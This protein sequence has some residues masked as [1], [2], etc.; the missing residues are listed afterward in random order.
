MV[1]AD[2]VMFHV[3]TQWL[4]IGLIILLLGHSLAR[5]AIIT[6]AWVPVFKGV[7]YTT[8]EADTNEVRLQKVF[9]F[10]LDLQEPTIE[11]FS[12]PANGTNGAL[13]TYGQTTTT[14]VNTYG[15]S[16][17]IN[18][19]FFSPVSTIP[20]D[21]RDL[22]GLAISG[23]D[24][25][26][27]FESGRPALL[28]TRSN[29][30]SIITSALSNY[31][32]YWTAVSGSD[33]I[34][35]NGVAQLASCTTSFCLE[36][37]RSALGYSANL[38]YLYLM[39]IDGRQPGWS[40]GATLYETGQW[41]LRLGA[42]NGLNLDGGG[43]TAL[44]RLESGSAILINRPSGGVQRVD[45]NHL[46]LFALPL[47]PM[48]VAQPQPTNGGLGQ[49]A[50]FT[51]TAGGTTPLRYQW[52]FNGTNISS[53]TSSSFAR[54]NLQLSQFG[55]YSVVITNFSG[56]I[57][58]STASLICANPPASPQISTHLSLS[59]ASVQLAVTADLGR[60]YSVQASS[61]LFQWVT[62]SK[63]F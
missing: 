62:L 35:I 55:Y 19:N 56:S 44:A 20:N 39:V 13:E 12:T 53:A 23:G 17:G 2:S 25:V 49:S 9:A 42:W 28:I 57:T 7:D 63:P 16:L 45:G 15:A 47:P 26:S 22:S 36:N 21:P 5:A 37:P 41:L 10:R 43:S 50:G 48:I 40:D 8:G 60:V 54:T 59:N 32:N 24:I 30:V 14:F 4:R 3:R 46:G 38:R 33:R 61:N 52:R 29:K 58:S 31:S 18:A 1:A 11:F 27:D 6:N 51:V 34:L